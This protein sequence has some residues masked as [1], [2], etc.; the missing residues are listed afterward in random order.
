M[1]QRD[2]EVKKLS[3]VVILE[4]TVVFFQVPVRTGTK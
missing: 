2:A 3:G 1:N 4:I